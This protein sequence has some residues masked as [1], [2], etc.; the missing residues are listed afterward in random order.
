MRQLSIIGILLLVT[1]TASAFPSDGDAQIR[2]RA[3]GSEI[4]ITTTRRLAGA[5]GSLTWNG[6]E[7]INATDHGR[8]LQSACSF[9]DTPTA[10]SETFNP[11]EAGSRRDGAGNKPTSRLLELTA[12]GNH[13]RTKTQMAFWLA[14]GERSNGQIARNTNTLS[15]YLLTKDVTIG[16]RRWPQ[17]LDYR[18]T[19]TMPAHTHHVFAQFEA[20]T[21]YMPPEFS[22][23][24]EFNPRTGKLQPLSD[25]PGEIE[26]P[27]VLATPDGKFAMG[28]FAP[29]QSQPH[30]SGPTY[31]RWSFPEA[32]VVKWNCVFRV[33]NPKGI[34]AGDYSYRMLVPIGTLAGVETMLCDWRN[35]KR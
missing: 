29:P 6:R 32:R 9:D 4:V 33:R 7:F 14:P 20:L 23:F 31:G 12:S 22:H 30:T 18:V 1:G 35:A 2:A 8:E 28:I 24:W 11:T 10:N 27:V 16:F 13:L 21:G 3:G 19:F 5:I 25:G 17:A 15:N 26:N 34:K